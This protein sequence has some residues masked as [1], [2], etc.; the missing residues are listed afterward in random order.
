MNRRELIATAAAGSLSL[1]LPA[2]RA[3]AG[4]T[5]GTPT[6]LVTAD[7]ESHV[8]ALDVSAKRILKRIRTPPGPRSIESAFMTWAVVAHT[9]SGRLS[10]LHAPS[11]AVRA[12]VGG[13]REPR[14]T[15][16][17]PFWYPASNHPAA[18]AIAYVTDSGRREVATVDV[19]RGRVVWRTAVPGPA[20][21]VAVSPD[22]TMLWTALG[23]KAER[24]AVLALDDPLRPR[25]R[26]TVAPPFLAHD[27]VFSGDGD[28]VWVTS[29][30]RRRIA[31][32]E[33]EGRRPVAF[34]DAGAPPQHVV[35]RGS[36]AYVA[37]GDDGTVRT[38][39]DDGVL[40]HEA[41]TPVGSY[42]VTLGW[43]GV[44]TPSLGR[45]T[46]AV[47]D[48]RGLLRDVRRVARAAHDACLVVSA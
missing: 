16:V 26:R 9:A 30:D 11:L 47:L 7:T 46:L 21:H 25:L 40:L 43:P 32:Y 42:N 31:V 48:D 1:A 18:R 45:G 6:A 23:T 29:G 20:R 27:V 12:V 39:R 3:E 34:V 28:H 35:F 13:L 2:G 44:L 24:V 38:H 5:G 4:A 17:Y 19:A 37:S 10:V 36:R 22:G 8:V 33:T 14:Y 15:A 41:R